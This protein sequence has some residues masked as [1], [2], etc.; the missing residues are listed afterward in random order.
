L[1]E[2]K[3]IGS[4]FNISRIK[5]NTSMDTRE[6]YKSIWRGERSDKVSLKAEPTVDHIS[7]AVPANK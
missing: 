5:N 6:E 4:F 1:P 7:T 2:D 3:R